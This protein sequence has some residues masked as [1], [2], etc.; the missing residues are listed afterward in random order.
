MRAIAF[1]GEIGQQRAALIGD[2][3]N[4]RVIVEGDLKRA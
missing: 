2:K 4:D 3:V 1:D